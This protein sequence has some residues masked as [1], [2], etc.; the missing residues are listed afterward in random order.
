MGTIRTEVTTCDECEQ[1]MP[2]NTDQRQNWLQ[3]TRPW[4]RLDFCSIE[5][6]A[7]WSARLAPA[8]NETEVVR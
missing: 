3:V 4:V 2:A 1:V 7:K 5:C 8:V 6:M